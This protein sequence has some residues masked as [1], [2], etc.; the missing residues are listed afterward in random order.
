MGAPPLVAGE[1]I[2][3]VTARLNKAAECFERDPAR[4]ATAIRS[5]ST[6]KPN[7]AGMDFVTI[8]DHDTTGGV[9]SRE[10]E[11]RCLAA[12]S[13]AGFRDDCKLHLLVYGITPSSSELHPEHCIYDVAGTSNHH[14]AR[15]RTPIYRQNDKL[16][17]AS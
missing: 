1:S 13:P 3:T 16:D 5:K 17:T 10:T 4:S 12:R 7:A 6:R 11:R 9:I 15:S 8:T 2:F 14:R